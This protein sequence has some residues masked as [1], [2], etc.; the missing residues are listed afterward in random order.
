MA[1]KIFLT[2]IC[3]LIL[4]LA[5][6]TVYITS[7]WDINTA[8]FAI[9]T[10]TLIALVFYAY[11]TF[12][13]ASVNKAKW[14]RESIARAT[15]SMEM[16]AQRERFRDRTL[17]RLTNLSDVVVMAKVQCNF[18][19]YG[20]RVESDN[21]AFEG[22]SIW[23]LFPHQMS[24]GWYEL[25]PLLAKK[26]KTV[27]QMIEERSGALPVSQKLFTTRRSSPSFFSE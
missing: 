4:G 1:M 9:L 5:G 26:G 11:H 13:I 24:Q 25:S 22:N 6:Y 16:A 21:D 19:I 12:S 27:D 10:L 2:I 7:N 23:V 18:K 14:D 8:S 15:Y 17:F 3:T 20:E